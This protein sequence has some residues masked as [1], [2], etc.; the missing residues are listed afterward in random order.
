[1]AF[2]VNADRQ[3]NRLGT[4]A[5]SITDFGMDAIKIDHRIHRIERPGLPLL[6]FI[7][8]AISDCRNKRG[9][10][11]SAI[12]FSKVLLDFTHRHATG[13]QRDDLVIKAHPA[14]LM[15]GN[16]LWLKT[17]FTVTGDLDRQFSE[18]TF[19]GLTAFTISGIASGIGYSFVLIV[20]KMLG[21]FC[22]QGTF[23]QRF[24]EL[25]EKTI[26]TD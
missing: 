2:H 12:H 18:F 7:H 10:H 5:T 25:L 13:I 14:S 3:V 20:T 21:Y 26:L 23:N 16:D 6:Y 17:A 19:Q 9:R 4:N 11:F 22:L 1:M 15:L 24:G 8:Y